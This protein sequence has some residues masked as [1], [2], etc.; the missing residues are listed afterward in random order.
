MKAIKHAINVKHVEL[1]LKI[2][3]I[4]VLQG[5]SNIST[6]NYIICPLT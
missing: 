3:I 1:L 2:L 4:S 5:I 6:A